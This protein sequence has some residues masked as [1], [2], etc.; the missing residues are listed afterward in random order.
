MLS[1]SR[2]DIDDYNPKLI[3]NSNNGQT[4]KRW[5]CLAF[6]FLC[7]RLLV[8]FDQ[9]W[10]CYLH[11]GV[12]KSPITLIWHMKHSGRCFELHGKGTQAAKTPMQVT[13]RKYV[14]ICILHN[15]WA[16]S[17]CSH[18]V[19]QSGTDTFI[20]GTL[21]FDTPW[22]ES[23][24]I[25]SSHSKIPQGR[26]ASF[27][28]RVG[29]YQGTNTER[30]F[31]WCAS[32]WRGVLDCGLFHGTWAQKTITTYASSTMTMTNLRSSKCTTTA[33]T[34]GL[35]FPSIVFLQFCSSWLCA[36]FAAIYLTY[37]QTPHPLFG[38]NFC[39]EKGTSE[40]YLWLRLLMR[41][42]GWRGKRAK[43]NMAC[44]R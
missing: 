43:R 36:S 6:Q 7:P 42:G 3:V 5:T 10:Y 29:A 14:V 26:F 27:Y 32:G 28:R 38:L 17:S 41:F 35:I 16:G 21:S 2:N 8:L 39:Y 24:I 30:W 23:L 4:C 19:P 34:P 11:Y 12:L 13:S 22:R 44:G 20:T 40:I 9:V 31:A 37:L 25:G 33:I 15:T 1:H 18:A